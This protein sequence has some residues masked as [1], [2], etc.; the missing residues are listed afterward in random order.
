M[1]ARCGPLRARAR[2]TRPGLPR[3]GRLARESLLPGI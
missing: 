1:A 3:P 2:G